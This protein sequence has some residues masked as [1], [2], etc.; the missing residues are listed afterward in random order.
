MEGE[1]ALTN[2]FKQKKRPQYSTKNQIS[3]DFQNK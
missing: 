1:D 2:D 3:F